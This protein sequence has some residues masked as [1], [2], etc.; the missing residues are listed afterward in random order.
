[1][2]LTL[3]NDPEERPQMAFALLYEEAVVGILKNIIILLEVQLLNVLLF[4]FFNY[5]FALLDGL[6]HREMQIKNL[7]NKIV[8]LSRCDNN[9]NTIEVFG[10][11]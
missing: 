1:M 3:N 11:R 6:G 5:S 4:F 8:A 7:K 10:P 2:C 9:I